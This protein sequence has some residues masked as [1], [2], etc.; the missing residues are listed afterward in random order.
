MG[1]NRH[2]WMHLFKLKDMKPDFFAEKMPLL[3]KHFWRYGS[4]WYC[5]AVKSSWLKPC[6]NSWNLLS[7]SE[8]DV[9]LY[10]DHMI[11]RIF[12]LFYTWMFRI[13]VSTLKLPVDFFFTSVS[14]ISYQNYKLMVKRLNNPETFDTEINM[15]TLYFPSLQCACMCMCTPPLM[16]MWWVGWLYVPSCHL[17]APTG[18][19]KATVWVTLRQFALHLLIFFTSFLHWQR[20][21]I[22]A[23]SILL[24]LSSLLLI[25]FLFLS[26]IYFFNGLLVV[27]DRLKLL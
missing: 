9:L 10:S 15:S 8:N 2:A 20:L 3:M 24:L 26:F 14:Q 1:E 7:L 11:G 18:F 23:H 5:R 27:L 6:T 4:I 22:W 21:Y 13:W 17:V 25:Y 16:C 19:A 12:L